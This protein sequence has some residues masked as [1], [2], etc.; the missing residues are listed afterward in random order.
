LNIQEYIQSG[1]VELYVA[2]ALCEEDARELESLALQYP[3]L[4]KEIEQVE[5]ALEAYAV[6]GQTEPDAALKGKILSAVKMNPA[7]PKEQPTAA[8]ETQTQDSDEEVRPLPVART[9]WL[10]IAAAVVLL[11]I[12]GAIGYQ[13]YQKSQQLESQITALRNETNQQQ[14]LVRDILIDPNYQSVLLKGN[15][16]LPMKMPDA[17]IKVFWNAETKQVHVSVGKLPEL[18][19]DQ[20]Y[21]LWALKDDQPIDAG[22]FEVNAGGIVQ[23]LKTIAAAD[24]WAVTI[25]PK[26]GSQQPHLDKLCLLSAG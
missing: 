1:V 25:E 13:F 26:G 17:E 23:P 24:K 3:E 10:A 14:A 7:T 18:G 15:E 22:V 8:V 11:L 19:E 12:S 16:K 5:L 6:A 2:R 4:K 20:Q 9:N 21:Q